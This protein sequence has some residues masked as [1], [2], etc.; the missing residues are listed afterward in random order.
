MAD[1]D[2]TGTDTDPSAGRRRAGA[3]IETGLA[4]CVLAIF[5]AR[6]AQD[7]GWALSSDRVCPAIY[8]APPSCFD[9]MPAAAV[10]TGVVMVLLC[11]A[12]VALLW[13]VGRRTGWIAALALL[14]QLAWSGIAYA[15][16]STFR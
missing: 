11:A 15:A 1:Q 4:L 6:L 12:S 14:T 16:A 9:I 5:G 10:I 13:T 8:P 3:W 7:A 2:M